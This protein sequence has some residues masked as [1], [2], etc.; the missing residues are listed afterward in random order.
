MD[1]LIQK[2]E[3]LDV[4]DALRGFAIASILT[5]HNLEHFDFIYYPE[6]LPNWL[7]AMDTTVWNTMFFLFGG[8]SY[9][10][11]ALLFGLTFYIQDSHQ[12][13][14][15]KDF[16]GRFAWRMLLLFLF[17]IVNSLFFQGDILT[18]FAVFGLI[19]IPTC[20]LKD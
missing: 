1:N 5:L 8:K 12:L 15:G 18:L 7:K 19:L 16:R 20:R 2:S 11:F 6:M 3:R 13:A 14:K 17:S 10:I 4:V 9:S